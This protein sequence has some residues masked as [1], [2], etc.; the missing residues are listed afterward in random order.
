MS[1]QSQTMNLSAAEL[2]WLPWFGNTGKLKMRW[3]CWLN[4]SRYS[5]VEAT[6]QALA[7][8]RK[9]ILLDWAE[10]K[11]SIL[12]RLAAD[13]ASSQAATLDQVLPKA[14]ANLEDFTELFVVNAQGQILGSNVVMHRGQRLE[15]AKALAL[16]LKQQFLHGPYCDPKTLQAGQSKSRFHDQVT[17]M[18]Y[19]PLKHASGEQWCLCG[20]IPNDVM[21]DL[22]QREAGHV[23]PESGD[24]YIFMIDAR[25][26]PSLEQGIALSRSRFE[27]DSFTGGENLRTGV[28]T[29]YGVVQIQNHTEFEVMFTDP[30]TNQLHPGVRETIQKGD[31][32]YVT[33]PGYADYRH[34]PVVGAGVTF[35]LKGSLDRWGMMCEGDLE[36]V[37]AFRSIPWVLASRVWGCTAL[38]G[39]AGM[40]TQLL[41]PEP[42]LLPVLASLGVVALGLVWLQYRLTTAFRRTEQVSSVLSAIAEHG[43]PLS[44][45]VEAQDWGTN[46]LSELALWVNSF[47]DRTESASQTLTKVAASVSKSADQLAHL[48][49]SAQTGAER[50]FE[51]AEDTSRAL[52]SIITKIAQVG[53]Q[54]QTTADT[55]QR[56]SEMS[57]EG[58]AQV[59]LVATDMHE[60]ASSMLSSLELVKSLE[61]KSESINSI[62]SVIVEIASQTNLLAL[63]ASIE[64][65]RAGEHGRG[66]AVVAD[67]VKSLSHRTGSSAAD[68]TEMISSILRET[69]Q[70]SARV[71]E[72]NDQVQR[73]QTSMVS[74][75]NALSVIRDGS[76]EAL[77]MVERI[78][79]LS[80]EQSVAGEAIAANIENISALIAR[81]RTDVLDAARSAHW[82][83]ILGDELNNAARKCANT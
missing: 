23:Y 63:N 74:A 61:D 81:N 25:F 59:K 72:C 29:D 27:D 56:A 7:E 48:T 32:I 80:Q 11:W 49:E 42:G 12:N 22:I 47:L 16:G 77:N 46:Q 51:A 21:S 2:G 5:Q 79:G 83:A 30:A 58:A 17:L 1:L 78:V 20:R 26:D 28:H 31:N 62:I 54:I 15:Q 33:Y 60:S 65:A 35:Q 68:I 9:K 43:Q 75:E 76:Q 69:K 66:F 36:E 3:S 73:G 6:F 70:V 44:G 57:S 14:I 18:F 52:D 34:I 38:A 53:S 64:A 24:N 10:L 13:L 8:N 71:Q 19:Q 82:L 45:R 4:R 50:Q 39:A 55:S 40:A 41:L 37:Y 67:E